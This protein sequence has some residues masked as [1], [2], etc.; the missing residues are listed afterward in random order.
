MDYD[1]CC[2]KRSSS[3]TKSR[4]RDFMNIKSIEVMDSPPKGP[5]Y[6]GNLS[7][8]S[9][10]KTPQK[11]VFTPHKLFTTSSKSKS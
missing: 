5:S 2:S 3:R 6:L 10:Q 11:Q 8:K 4:E 9:G 1:H 7:N